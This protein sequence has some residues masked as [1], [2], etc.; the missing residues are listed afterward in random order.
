MDRRDFCKSLVSVKCRTCYT[1]QGTRRVR[2]VSDILSRKITESLMTI[3]VTTLW[4]RGRGKMG[5]KKG[6]REDGREK[7]GEGR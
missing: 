3:H 4:K 2:R 7:G 5:E 1:L 6:E